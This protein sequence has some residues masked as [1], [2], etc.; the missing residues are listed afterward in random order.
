MSVDSA[1]NWQRIN[2]AKTDVIN[3]KGAFMSEE[4][5]VYGIGYLFGYLWVHFVRNGA[6]QVLA[7]MLKTPTKE[8]RNVNC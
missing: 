7:E 6:T 8:V 3:K 1:L 5:K 2:Q 4:I